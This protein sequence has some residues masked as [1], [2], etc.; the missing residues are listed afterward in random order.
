M[1]SS[2]VV[3]TQAAEALATIQAKSLRAHIRSRIHALATFPRI[4]MHDDPLPCDSHGA[5]SRVTCVAPYAIRYRY[6]P[7]HAKVVVDAIT[8]ERAVSF[9]RFL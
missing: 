2:V 7:D 3:A 5:E 8:D 4:G 6:Y 1:R 9:T